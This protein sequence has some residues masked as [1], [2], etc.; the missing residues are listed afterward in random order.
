MQKSNQQSVFVINNKLDEKLSMVQQA[1][2]NSLWGSTEE[3]VFRFEFIQYPQPETSYM[4]PV[5]NNRG[6]FYFNLVRFT[7]DFKYMAFQTSIQGLIG[8]DGLIYYGGGRVGMVVGNNIRWEDGAIWAKIDNI[9]RARLDMLDI[10]SI[11]RNAYRDSKAI[12]NILNTQ[13]LY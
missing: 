3:G 2:A 11:Q 4:F 6:V 1:L 5:S 7:P 8:V 9:P 10:D 12:G 13:Y